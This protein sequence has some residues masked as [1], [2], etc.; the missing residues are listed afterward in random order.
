MGKLE[1]VT[2][3]FWGTLVDGHHDL[4]EVRIGLLGARLPEVARERIAA[5]YAEGW[6]AFSRLLGQGIG[7]G[8]ATMLSQV[9]GTLGAT[10]APPDYAA[11]LRG[12]EEAMI[13]LPP[14]FLPGAAETLAALRRRGLRLGLIS[15]TGASPGRVTRQVLAARGLLS[16]F[17]WLTFSNEI[18][19]GKAQPFPFRQTLRA[20]GVPPERAIHVGDMPETDIAGAHAAGMAAALLLES[21]N[22]RDGIAPEGSGRAGRGTYA[23]LIVGRLAEL[24]DALEAWM[25]R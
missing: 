7:L 6:K 2:L 8:T 5:A 11:V 23:D 19:V 15:D 14:A 16:A 1:A 12:W 4:R 10:L 20:L 9:L 24:P 13:D 3:D 22:R 21:G 17:D 25:G 18:G